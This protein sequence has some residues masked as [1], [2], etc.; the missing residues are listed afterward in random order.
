MKKRTVSF[1]AACFLL[2]AQ[3]CLAQGNADTILYNGKILTVDAQSSVAEAVAVSGDRILAVGTNEEVLGLAGPDTLQIDLKGKT[4]TPGLI[5]THVHMESPG[6]YGRDLPASQSKRYP[7]NFRIVQT[8]EDVIKQIK[9]TIA[10]F[11]FEPGEW[12]PFDQT[13]ESGWWRIVNDPGRTHR[14]SAVPGH[15]SRWKPAFQWK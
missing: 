8:K 2:T 3:L 7:L 14:R 12:R 6:R 5:H 13:V 4:V 10:A 1:A 15:D 9:D 11:Q